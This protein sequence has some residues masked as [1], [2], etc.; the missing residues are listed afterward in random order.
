MCFDETI[1]VTGKPLERTFNLF[2]LTYFIKD[3]VAP[4]Q[5]KYL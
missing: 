1:P 5:V 3:L 2:L 4:N